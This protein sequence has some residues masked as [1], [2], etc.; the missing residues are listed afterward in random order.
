MKVDL[1]TVLDLGYSST[2][3]GY[4]C[5]KRSQIHYLPLP[6]ALEF[7][8][9]EQLERYHS[10][11]WMK[12]EVIN[13]AWV[14]V[15]EK[16]VATG[17]LAEQ[18]DPIDPMSELKY[19]KALFKTLA[20]IGICAELHFTKMKRELSVALSILLPA[21][22]YQ[23]RYKF[24]EKLKAY[25]EKGYKFRDRQ[26]QVKL[27]LFVPRPEGAGLAIALMIEKEKQWWSTQILGVLVFG[28]RNITG[29]VFKNG[30]KDISQSPLLGFTIFLDLVIS[31]KSGLEPQLLM[32][33]I[34]KSLPIRDQYIEKNGSVSGFD[35]GR[36]PSIAALATAR[37]LDLRLAEIA[38]IK[39]A[40]DFAWVEYWQKITKRFL[41]KLVK[42]L[43]T[44]VI[45][46]GTALFLAPLLEDFFNC[47][48]IGITENGSP[49]YQP[50]DSEK[51]FTNIIW[52][53]LIPLV[54]NDGIK[55]T[56]SELL[57]LGDDPLTLYQSMDV[58]SVLLY[59]HAKT[60]SV[61]KTDHNTRL[62]LKR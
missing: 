51:P 56:L 28:H 10:S 45:S 36:C 57:E 17:G 47:R 54:N 15:D 11:N 55:T 43:D 16:I 22:E 27:E 4:I 5:G 21:N 29:H 9:A 61:K 52:G 42:D 18:F 20:A 41:S 23:D 40:I 33:A 2:K 50:K 46:G 19:E 14:E 58:T 6:P 34:F 26:L 25:L 3:I 7:V 35:W 48:A 30:I 1:E 12:G 32:K 38:E 60:K 53:H 13:D 39:N 44:V 8:T 24:V 31:R 59:L 49:I 62:A 37:D